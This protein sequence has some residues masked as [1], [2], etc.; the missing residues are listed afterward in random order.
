MW[1]HRFGARSAQEANA[2][3]LSDTSVFVSGIFAR[4]VDF[5]G[6]SLQSAGGTDVFLLCLEP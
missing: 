6:G 3:A 4:A 1:S 2:V 5:G